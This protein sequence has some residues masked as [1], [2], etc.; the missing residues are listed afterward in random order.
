MPFIV[1][2]DKII[3]CVYLLHVSPAEVLPTVD[4]ENRHSVTE[5]SWPAGIND[6]GL[7]L[8]E[9]YITN[10]AANVQNSAAACLYVGNI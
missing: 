8:D 6:G 1:I 5:V 9:L 7:Q 4:M 3:S 2:E 10:K